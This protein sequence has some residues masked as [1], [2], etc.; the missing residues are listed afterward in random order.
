[1]SKRRPSRRERKIRARKQALS[2]R[3]IELNELDRRIARIGLNRTDRSDVDVSFTDSDLG[4]FILPAGMSLKEWES[5][6]R[7]RVP[8]EMRRLL[9]AISAQFRREIFWSQCVKVHFLD[10]ITV[11]HPAELAADSTD[12]E[13]NVAEF[14]REL[15]RTGYLTRRPDGDYDATTPGDPS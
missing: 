6:W 13:E 14:F 3:S 11:V 4:E 1:M 8:Q 12:D 7:S 15:E 9:K 2:R 10:G 5:D